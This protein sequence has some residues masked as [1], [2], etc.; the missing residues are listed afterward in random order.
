MFDLL[1]DY[2][3]F[4]LYLSFLSQTIL[5]LSFSG[6]SLTSPSYDSHPNIASPT[7]LQDQV[8]NVDSIVHTCQ[9]CL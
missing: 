4:L 5:T 1:A 7:H 8:L 2:L 3:R 6:V 9:A